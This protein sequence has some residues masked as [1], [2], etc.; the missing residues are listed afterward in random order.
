MS[1]IYSDIRKNLANIFKY[2]ELSFTFLTL[3]KYTKDVIF[4]WHGENFIESFCDRGSIEC[5]FFDPTRYFSCLIDSL[6]QLIC[7]QTNIRTK[8]FEYSNI[9]PERIYSY[10]YTGQIW[11]HEYICIRIH[12]KWIF[13]I[14]LIFVFVVK[15]DIRHTLISISHKASG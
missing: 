13:R 14:Y 5:N 7:I 11:Y 8:I 3:L 15:N 1:Q 6:I 12:A 10:S 9:S 4:Q 2:F